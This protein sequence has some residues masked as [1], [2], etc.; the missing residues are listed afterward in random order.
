[1]TRVAWRWTLGGLI[2]WAAHFLAVY[3]IGEF[4]GEGTAPRVT[5]GALTAVA[6]IAVVGIGTRVRHISTDGDFARWQRSVAGVGA[7]LSAIAILWQALPA[8]F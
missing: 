2:V 1:M 4:W 8:L 5:I 6:L 3:A 7:L